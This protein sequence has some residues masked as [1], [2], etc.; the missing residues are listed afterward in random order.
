MFTDQS[1][2]TPSF[3]RRRNAIQDHRSHDHVEVALGRDVEEVHLLDSRVLSFDVDSSDFEPWH[4]QE[5][6]VHCSDLQN[7]QSRLMLLR[8][9]TQ[10][11]DDCENPFAGA[12]AACG[13]NRRLLICLSTAD[14]LQLAFELCFLGTSFQGA[15]R[16]RGCNGG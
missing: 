4:G 1:E 6:R 10:F 8:A 15:S 12:M 2:H 11:G 16:S 7:S 14:G 3:R 13:E 9:K 5:L